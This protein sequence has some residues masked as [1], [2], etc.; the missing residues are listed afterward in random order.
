MD[1]QQVPAYA[2]AERR[3]VLIDA[4]H[5]F[6]GQDLVQNDPWL[7]GR[8]IRMFSHGET[9]DAAMMRDQFPDM[10]RVYQDEHGSVWSAASPSGVSGGNTK[11]T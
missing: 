7:R 10:H 1:M 5:S 8:V 2:G 3:V 9:A 6:Y 4:S 11:G